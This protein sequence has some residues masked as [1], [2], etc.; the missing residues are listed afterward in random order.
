MISAIKTK[1]ISALIVISVLISSLDVGFNRAYAADDS[2]RNVQ[3]FT[4]MLKETF[5]Q[6]GIGEVRER[7]HKAAAEEFDLLSYKKEI[8]KANNG[9]ALMVEVAVHPS[10]MAYVTYA[11]EQL[12]KNGITFI[13]YEAVIDPSLPPLNAPL[14]SEEKQALYWK[15]ARSIIT[16][17]MGFLAT[18]LMD[19]QL[20]A[21]SDLVQ[22]AYS[23][24]VAHPLFSKNILDGISIDPQ[25]K[26][27]LIV[28]TTIWVLEQQFN[29]FTNS[30]AK[31]WQDSRPLNIKIK[32]ATFGE[33]PANNHFNMTVNK[34]II[35]LNQVA[36]AINSIA[37]YKKNELH[38]MSFNDFLSQLT[39]S[40]FWSYLVNWG[41][42]ASLYSIGLYAGQQLGLTHESWDFLDLVMKSGVMTSAFYLAF[43][44]DQVIL[45]QLT[46]R[47]E[48]TPLLR[49]KIESTA[50]YWNNFWRV[51][52]SV[53]GLYGLGVGMQLAWGAVITAPLYWKL[54]QLEK[55]NR[56][57][58]AL[59]ERNMTQK[60][61]ASFDCSLVF[62]EPSA[63]LYRG[64]TMLGI[65]KK[66]F[67]K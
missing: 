11:N 17:S 32:L 28:G 45:A 38:G 14:P 62:E 21:A 61:K 3:A 2:D 31:L 4:Q 55:R 8:L 27:D 29:W 13:Q 57:T 46:S 30:W 6:Y 43:G 44:L 60:T 40:H 48:I 41:Y 63:I 51:A 67:G 64:Q 10:N 20:G 65:G 49:Q 18:I 39:Y 66:V 33:L 52:S 34:L 5:E 22:G 26:K 36:T 25:L 12:S 56:E 58:E 50:G 23:N 9:Q 37:N 19:H 42:A 35:K 47:G 16:P 24:L 15:I 7:L 53:P 54:D 1:C 59:F